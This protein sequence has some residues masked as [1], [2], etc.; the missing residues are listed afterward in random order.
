MK[1]NHTTP[2]KSE[3][4]AKSCILL[5]LATK[6]RIKLKQTNDIRARGVSEKKGGRLRV[7]PFEIIPYFNRI[8]I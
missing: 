1:L 5:L 2:D 4:M 6:A 8:Q 7:S 3:K